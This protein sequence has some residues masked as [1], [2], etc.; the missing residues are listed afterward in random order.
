[1]RQAY[2]KNRK[3]S[4][5]FSEVV[6]QELKITFTQFAQLTGIDRTLISRI[7]NGKRYP[8]HDTWETIVE[9]SKGS[10]SMED[11]DERYSLR[12]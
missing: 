8:S 3:I 6:Q 1:M 12:N 5:R 9:H 7:A 11:W 2:A 10:L 4:F